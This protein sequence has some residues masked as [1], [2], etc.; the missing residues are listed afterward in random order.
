MIACYLNMVAIFV[1]FIFV[2]IV[3]TAAAAAAG[4]TDW[5]RA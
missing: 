1:D 2:V 3:S 4:I 5:Y